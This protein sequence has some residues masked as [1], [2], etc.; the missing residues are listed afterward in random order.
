M[1]LRIEHLRQAEKQGA[2]QPGQAEALWKNLGA[3]TADEP[4]FQ[5][6]HIVYYFGAMLMLLP[7]TIFLG[8]A[9][10]AMGRGALACV[11]AVFAGGAH[12]LADHLKKSGWRSPAGIFGCVA[13]ALVPYITY[14][15]LKAF[16]VEFTESYREF[17][18]FIDARWI[19]VELATLAA[20][21]FALWRIREP[22][23]VLP[24]AASFWYFGMDFVDGLA[25]RREL[26][27]QVAVNYTIAFGIAVLLFAYLLEKRTRQTMR[28]YSFWLWIFGTMSF[29]GAMSF[30]H[31]SVEWGSFSYGAIN[32][33]MIVVGGLVGRRVLA[34][35]GAVG[36]AVYLWCLL[37]TVFANSL[38]FS[39]IVV[40]LGGVLVWAAMRWP[41]VEAWFKLKLAG[42]RTT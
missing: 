19:V 4:A 37:D 6:R 26:I 20:A 38:A 2:L 3:Q 42:R 14:L 17:H 41:K 31:T 29:W 32:I 10:L 28:D 7:L 36:S 22:V 34:V 12:F 13:V 11:L 18:R 21:A 39:I 30:E 33:A 27:S 23:L 24:V 1:K 35:F 9:L 5:L 25:A 8:P 16:G 15:G 40:A